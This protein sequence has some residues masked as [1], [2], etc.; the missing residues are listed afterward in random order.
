MDYLFEC[1]WSTEKHDEIIKETYKRNVWN[2]LIIVC[3]IFFIFYLAF[4]IYSAVKN[5][6]R[7]IFD[8]SP[9]VI[10]LIAVIIYSFQIYS[11]FHAVKMNVKRRNEMGLK[12]D[13]RIAVSDDAVYL[14]VKPDD[15]TPQRVE[16]KSFKKVMQTKNL[17]LMRSQAK[18]I[19]IFPKEYFIKGTP[20]EFIGFLK[21]KGFKVHR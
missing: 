10:I 17:I 19:Y 16:F 6:N 7:L 15:E 1:R 20:D 5:Y 11:Y 8:I 13:S 18:L 4:G 12:C 2:P 14:F 21:S 3:D 9:Y